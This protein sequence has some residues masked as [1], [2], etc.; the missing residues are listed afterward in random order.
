MMSKRTP[1]SQQGE[2]QGL[3]GSLTALAMMLAQLT[4]NFT[5]AAFTEVGAAIRFPGAP[6][7]IAACIGGTALLTLFLLPKA[8]NTTNG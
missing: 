1:P 4:F 2:L 3:I 8:D 6:F 7:V 5:L